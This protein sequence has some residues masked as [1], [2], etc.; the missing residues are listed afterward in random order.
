MAEASR[1]TD[2]RLDPNR[3]AG[4]PNGQ[5]I[6]TTSPSRDPRLASRPQG[7]SDGSR[8]PPGGPPANGPPAS[9]SPSTSFG[10]TF[11]ESLGQLTMEIAG[12]ATAQ[13][14]HAKLKKVHDVLEDYLTKSKNMA[15]FPS[16]KT[17]F[18]QNRKDKAKELSLIEQKL[19]S[20]HRQRRVLEQTVATM[21]NAHSKGGSVTDKKVDQI[22]DDA[23]RA[24]STTEDLKKEVLE[25]KKEMEALRAAQDAAKSLDSKLA[26]VDRLVKDIAQTVAFHEKDFH[27][28]KNQ[29]SQLDNQLSQ[30]GNQLASHIE[31]ASEQQK[32]SAEARGRLDKLEKEYSAMQ[33]NLQ[34]LPEMRRNYESLEQR[35]GKVQTDMDELS[36]TTPNRIS[37]LDERLS[38]LEKSAASTEAVKKTENVL[39]DVKERIT[40]IEEVS[41]SAK[42]S[43][44]SLAADNEVVLKD[45][46]NRLKIL[47]TSKL[48]VTTPKNDALQSTVVHLRDKSNE[49]DSKV[50]FLKDKLDELFGVHALRDELQMEA[51][52]KAEER[53]KE[54]LK[55]MIEKVKTDCDEV[56]HRLIA[57][58]ESRTEELDKQ[59]KLQS[60]SIAGLR[61]TIEHRDNRLQAVE[62][63]I[64]SLETRYNHLTT[65]P[66]VRQTISA[67]QEI[68]PSAQILQM[69]VDQV[70]A[71][72]TQLSQ[73]NIPE[74]SRL[75][76]RLE[77]VRTTL[78]EEIRNNCTYY[79]NECR[80]LADQHA[81][82]AQQVGAQQRRFDTEVP[83]LIRDMATMREGLSSLEKNSRAEEEK[84][85]TT[86]Q[87]MNQ[88]IQEMNQER[89]RMVE[90]ITSITKQ[91]DEIRTRTADGLKG[92]EEKIQS[93]NSAEL[94]KLYGQIREMEGSVG[95]QIQELVKSLDD[96]KEKSEKEI[97]DAMA[98]LEELERTKEMIAERFESEAN[99]E[100]SGS[101]PL[102]PIKVEQNQPSGVLDDVPSVM[103]DTPLVSPMVANGV[104]K[105]H[106]KKKKKRKLLSGALFDDEASATSN[107]PSAR[108]SPV[109]EEGSSQ[110]SRSEKKHKKKKRK[111]KHWI[112]D[113]S[114]VITL[115]D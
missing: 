23:K 114:Q 74:V 89:D 65:E 71:I 97:Q 3:S 66:I 48:T 30:L 75:S 33:T 58:T 44:D 38:L 37:K 110:L 27:D 12:I 70:A 8:P 88:T 67:M 17:I 46:E 35:V 112:S 53:L 59:Y 77:A 56:S 45:I 2:P 39:E 73:M 11:V 87:E 72:R 105:R 109:P 15:Q 69:V 82:L 115:D 6:T 95:D 51:I 94:E 61:E 36:S 24:L 22:Q 63:A 18:S 101:L 96:F 79:T 25:M 7:A 13:N 5:S 29:F 31:S 52:D 78:T 21:L 64:V 16:T 60:E 90:Q 81:S 86:I 28:F 9:G 108:S 103:S 113:P 43:V 107:S 49:L 84:R 14:E 92:M 32:Y 47:E 54:E 62:T 50:T 55:S 19:D 41:K 42:A 99:A 57:P 98:R 68:Y 4:G 93:A 80:R 85:R 26:A 1:P 34:I 20:H 91:M 100:E 83:G 106:E 10:Q 76:S 104:V 40:A 102:R 111:K